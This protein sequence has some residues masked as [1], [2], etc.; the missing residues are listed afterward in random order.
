MSQR[1]IEK[2]HP[3]PRRDLSQVRYL[4]SALVNMGKVVEK[5][6]VSDEV[7]SEFM[8]HFIHAIRAIE[9]IHLDNKKIIQQRDAILQRTE[10]FVINVNLKITSTNTLLDKLIDVNN[11]L[12]KSHDDLQNKLYM[13]TQIQRS[14]EP[15]QIIKD[16]NIIKTMIINN[17]KTNNVLDPADF[18]IDND[19]DIDALMEVIKE[20]CDKKQL[21]LDKDI[22]S[23]LSEELTLGLVTDKSKIRQLL[24]NNK[25]IS[26]TLDPADFAI[27]N[28]LDIDALMKVI[29]ELRDEKHL[30]Y[31]HE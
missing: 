16:K 11:D 14:N 9:E 1:S 27:D 30:V 15:T 6:D 21:V 29:D 22:D 19:L 25:K 17:K 13:Y 5:Y 2:H 31:V 8:P 3:V 24:F 23:H 18:A 26:N 12:I 10:Q 28:D 4:R 20:L 7:A